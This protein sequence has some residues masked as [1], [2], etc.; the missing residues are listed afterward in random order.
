MNLASPFWR[1]SFN[2]EE[3]DGGRE[4]SDFLGLDFSLLLAKYLLLGNLLSHC[5]SHLELRLPTVATYCRIIKRIKQDNPFK[6]FITLPASINVC[7][8]HSLL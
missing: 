2:S 6:E 5:V 1:K 7:Q 3:N 4:R 8:H